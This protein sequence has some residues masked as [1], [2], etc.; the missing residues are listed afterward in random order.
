MDAV[1]A[2][3]LAERLSV[4]RTSICH[5]VATRLLKA[6]PELINTLR[7]EVVISVE[8]HMSEVSA[9][10]LCE[11]VRAILIFNL[12]TLADKELEWACGVLPRSGITYRHQASLIHWFFDEVRLLDLSAGEVA[13]THELEQYMLDVLDRSYTFKK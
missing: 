9:E 13:I 12:P 3:Y 4:S 10:R 6:F 8:T 11:L 5:R 1:A 2:T 7:S